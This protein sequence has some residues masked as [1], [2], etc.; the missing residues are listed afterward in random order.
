MNYLNYKELDVRDK[1]SPW[2]DYLNNYKNNSN[3][4][5]KNNKYRPIDDD[6]V[7]KMK[8][9]Y[10]DNKEKNKRRKVRYYNIR[11]SFDIETTS[12]IVEGYKK[13]HM[14]IWQFCIDGVV[15]VGRNLEELKT[16]LDNLKEQ[17]GLNQLLRLVIY[18]HNLGYEFQFIQSILNKDMVVFADSPR[19][20]MYINDLE[21]FE[22]RCSYRLT[23]LG[24]SKV[25]DNLPKEYD[26]LKKTDGLDYS[27]I[28]HEFTP[29]TD[30]EMEYCI[31]D[32]LILDAYIKTNIQDSNQYDLATIP[33]TNTG[34]VRDYCRKRCMKND[35]YKKKIGNLKLQTDEFIMLRR[36]FQGG[37]THANASY[38]DEVIEDVNSIDFTSSYPT[39][40][41]AEKFPMSV[42]RRIYKPKF[43]EIEEYRKGNCCVFNIVYK[44][45]RLKESSPDCPISY[46]KC[47]TKP[48]K[49]ILSDSDIR[50]GVIPENNG[51]IYSAE[52]CELIVT[53]MDFDTINDYYN[54]ESAE[55][56]G[57]YY[58]KAG[59][60]PSDFV[61][62][63][64]NLYKDKTELKDVEG[65]EQEY[66]L[67]KGMLNSCYGM[68][69]T[70]FVKPHVTFNEGWVTTPTDLREE[71]D[72]QND[73][74]KRFLFYP[75][76]VWIRAYA[77][78]NLLKSML[79]FGSDYIYA[80]TDSIKFLNY[81]KHKKFIKWY[82][83]DIQ[84]KLEKAI[85]YH[86]R[87]GKNFEYD[88]NDLKPKTIKGKE[89]PL[90]VWDDDGHY[91][92]FKTLGAK[93][94]VYE[95]D[96]GQFCIT[97]AGLPKKKGA[98]AILNK[99]DGNIDSCFEF[100]NDNMTVAEKGLKQA[101]CYIDEET[102]YLCTDY[103]GFTCEVVSPS[104]IYLGDTSF[105]LKLTDRFKLYVDL[106]KEKYNNE[107]RKR[108]V[109]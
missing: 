15:Y 52:V 86:K 21:G 6:T 61:R 30:E 66:L 13:A 41:I 73:D 33:L 105:T 65:K 47:I 50:D 51:R 98:E 20:P 19:E 17:L 7:N 99:C 79:E 84:I 16:F 23:G 96:N 8:L 62:C 97:I 87:Y 102:S 49:Y 107:I 42:G 48:I 58:Y 3:F 40:M 26:W 32:V 109:L 27:K 5:F 24:L 2:A 9:C 92:K 63:V 11:A 22:F 25:A 94:Y 106:L 89:K 57:G 38:V 54:Y 104:A 28:R 45:L 83:K 34:F 108:E 35:D 67:S 91:K 72:K 37:F 44:N 55:L 56:K 29:M 82:N 100:F 10:E 31:N 76:G 95:K 18:V 103:N 70:N 74:A 85:K 4:K 53:D 36:A 81:D 1:R 60:L 88:V 68:C 14:Y 80:D 69:V 46:S 75:W 101:S 59:Y 77:R 71:V 12:M 39:V 93:R 43:E 90:G 64:L 78:R